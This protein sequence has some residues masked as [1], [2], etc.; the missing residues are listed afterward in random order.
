MAAQ[1]SMGAVRRP[2]QLLGGPGLFCFVRTAYPTPR[3]P[4][5]RPEGHASRGVVPRGVVVYPTS[6]GVCTPPIGDPRPNRLPLCSY[7]RSCRRRVVT[8]HAVLW[9]CSARRAWGRNLVNGRFPGRPQKGLS[10]DVWVMGGIGP[11]RKRF[12]KAERGR[13]RDFWPFSR[14]SLILG[15]SHGIGSR[16]C[17]NWSPVSPHATWYGTPWPKDVHP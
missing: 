11:L 9:E 15:C 8:V 16:T 14:N 2:K 10:G 3:E 5:P 17:P 13:V 1:L 6:L 7:D 12:F 4:M